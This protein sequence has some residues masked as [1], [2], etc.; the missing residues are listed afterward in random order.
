MAT[1][2]QH[3]IDVERRDWLAGD[4]RAAGLDRWIF[5][6]TA[7]IFVGVTLIGFIPDSIV[8]VAAVSAG[9]RPPFPWLLHAHAVL[10]GSFLMLL[11]TQ[12]WLAATGR[13]GLHM[14]LG[15]LAAAIA[16]ALVVVGF[17]LA[18]AMYQQTLHAEQAASSA[19]RETLQGTLA[20]KENIMLNQTRLGVVFPL[21]MVIGL[22][23]RRH[24]A[25]LHK[26]MMILATAT[27]MGPAIIRIHW[28]PQTFPASPLS[29]DL[30]ILLMI[31][32][33]FVRDVMRN[34]YI[35]RAYLI[36]VG[37]SAPFV[38]MQYMLW[39]TPWWH[40]TARAILT[41]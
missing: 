35:H 28:L 4:E 27:V 5:V 36:W 19:L 13:I 22:I 38:V 33:L 20:R 11:L 32:P 7:A 12:T 18:P 1:A 10:M 41:A 29:T 9:T 23:A 30:Y 34:G 2:A 39:D 31:A 16:A 17:L 15:I 21:C 8:K 37:C 6:L 40:A 26:R 14:Q 24:D 3:A 25:G